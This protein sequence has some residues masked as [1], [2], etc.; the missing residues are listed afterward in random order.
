M[1]LE[2]FTHVIL[3]EDMLSH[4]SRLGFCRPAFRRL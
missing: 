1:K 3:T 4:G 2:R